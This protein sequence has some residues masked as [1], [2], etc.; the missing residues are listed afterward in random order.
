MEDIVKAVAQKAGLSNSVAQTVVNTVISMLSDKLPGNLGSV[1]SSLTGSKKET[2][3]KKTTSK[4]D[5]GGGLLGGLG[6]VLGG[7]LGK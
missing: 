6:D 1:L 2:T 3:T 7:L 4:D 5:D